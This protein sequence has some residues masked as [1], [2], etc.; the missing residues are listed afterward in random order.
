MSAH[1]LFNLLNRFGKRDKMRGLSSILSLFPNEFNKFNN[2]RARILDYIY[3]IAT[4]AAVS[5]GVGRSFL[6]QPFSV[7]IMFCTFWS[8][9]NIEFWQKTQV[10][11]SIRESSLGY[12]YVVALCMKKLHF[13]SRNWR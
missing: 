12:M 9:R 5:C 4:A 7:G 13:I 6:V 3:H 1:V 8:F 10:R 11:S 2:T